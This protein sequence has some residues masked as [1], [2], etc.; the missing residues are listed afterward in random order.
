MID[1]AGGAGGEGDAFAAI[2]RARVHQRFPDSRLRQVADYLATSARRSV[3]VTMELDPHT[4]HLA[5]ALGLR[6][7]GSGNCSPS[8]DD[9][10]LLTRLTALVEAPGRPETANVSHPGRSSRRPTG[11]AHWSH[12]LCVMSVTAPSR[13][14]P[15]L[16]PPASLPVP[17]IPI[18][19]RGDRCLYLSRS[20]DG[21]PPGSIR[22]GEKLW[23]P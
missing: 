14:W 15:N 12:L 9:A 19:V 16:C 20:T 11:P 13:I 1:T 7:P 6:Q 23:R 4:V 21:S 17:M 10:R 2:W 3:T 5:L 22:E 18:N 8:F